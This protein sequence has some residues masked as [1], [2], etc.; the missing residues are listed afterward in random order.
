MPSGWQVY[1]AQHFTIAYPGE[2]IVQI[3]P[4]ASGE[5]HCEFEST[6]GGYR[7]Q[8]IEE[9][10]V[11]VSVVATICSSSEQVVTFAGLPMWYSVENYGLD[12]SP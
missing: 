12:H 7:V 6:I 10:S 8:V 11:D 2:W 5:T 4:G 1:A 9:D 3:A